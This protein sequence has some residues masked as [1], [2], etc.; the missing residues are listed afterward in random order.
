MTTLDRDT[1]DLVLINT[2]TVDPTRADALLQVLS[3]ATEQ[4]MRHMP[5]F[6][7]AKLHVSA[8]KHHVANYARWRS[9]ED[10]QAM[11]TKPEAQGHMKIAA[12]LAESFEPIFYTVRDYIQSEPLA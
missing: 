6:I 3:E 5:G 12:G 4:V 2:F 11:M 8:D 10:V 1:Q 9:M 7:S